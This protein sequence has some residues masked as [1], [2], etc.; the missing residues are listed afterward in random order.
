MEPSGN[1]IDKTHCYAL[2]SAYR[3]VIRCNRAELDRTC[4]F[5]RVNRRLSG[6]QGQLDQP[7]GTTIRGSRTK[8]GTNAQ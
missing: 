6:F 7:Q 2:M 4:R 5:D 8:S 1:Y 3:L